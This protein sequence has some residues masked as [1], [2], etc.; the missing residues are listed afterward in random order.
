MHPY[1]DLGAMKIPEQ[2]RLTIWR[3]LQD[4]KQGAALQLPASTHHH[5]YHGQQLLR[6]SSNM[7]A[8][9]MAAI[10]AGG[11][12]Q[13]QRVME[14]VHFRVRHTITIPNRGGV[15]GSSGMAT[16]TDEWADFGFDMPDCKM[17]RSKHSIK[18]EF[19]ESDV[20]WAPKSQNMFCQYNRLHM[21][22]DW[23][24]I[25]RESNSFWG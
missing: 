1:Q 6:S 20:H 5:D 15:V 4:M 3:G 17:S 12:L 22:A 19:M 9:A 13:R 18:E 23:K 14:A 21:F 10:G 24:H 7:T 11:E 25:D 16:A 8:S 2:S